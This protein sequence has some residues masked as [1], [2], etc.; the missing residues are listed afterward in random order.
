[1]P[2]ANG[3]TYLAIPGPSVVPERVLGAMHAP[4]PNIYDGPLIDMVDTLYPDLKAVAK[5]GGQVAIYIGNGHGA[6]EAALSNVASRGDQILVLA[7]GAFGIGWAEAATGLG[8]RAKVLDFGKQSGLDLAQVSAVLSKD[9]SHKIK[10]VMCVHADTATSLKIDIAALRACIDQSDHPALLMVDCIASLGCDAFEMDKWGVDVTVAASQKGLMLPPGL[11]FIFFNEK[12]DVAHKSADL[13]TPYWNWTPRA[14][15][16]KFYRK[17]CGT[18]PT[19]HLLGLRVAL[20]M[21]VKEE[22]IANVW[23]RHEKLARSVWAALDVWG[24]DGPVAMNVKTPALRSCAVTT[25]NIGAPLGTKLRKWVEENTGVTLGISLGM[26][27][28]DDPAWHGYF[29][30][31]HMGHVNAHMTMGVLGVIEAGLSAL[32]IP[33]GRGALDAAAAIISKA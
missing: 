2:L 28:A 22:G 14:D 5:T 6:W 21:L 32:D 23:E 27:D 8:I 16:D 17:F 20:D 15:A 12:A 10:A 30:I 26:A 25:V 9:K 29:R 4:S 31:A 19:H 24:A 7:T 1:M 18:A 13:T 3:R 11:F 33:H